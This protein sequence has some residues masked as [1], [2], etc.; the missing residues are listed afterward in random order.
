[1]LNGNMCQNIAHRKRLPRSFYSPFL[2]SYAPS[3][4][5]I[6][7]VKRVLL[8]YEKRRTQYDRLK[9]KEKNYVFHQTTSPWKDKKK[10]G[11][12]FGVLKIN[13]TLKKCSETVLFP[14]PSYLASG[15]C[16]SF[17]RPIFFP[18]R[19]ERRNDWYWPDRSEVSDSSPIAHACIHARMPTF[20]VLV[21][22]LSFPP[23][24]L[25]CSLT[26]RFVVK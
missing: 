19:S 24:P 20:F 4:K 17:L 26:N 2:I 1:M 14:N 21:A 18:P 7:T 9:E 15:L 10:Y 3:Q 8:M 5:R 16:H 25:F 13:R 22:V 23:S 11:N 12:L 6:P